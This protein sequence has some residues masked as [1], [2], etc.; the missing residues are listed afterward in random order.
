MPSTIY[1]IIT[2]WDLK[3]TVGYIGAIKCYWHSEGQ[4]IPSLLRVVISPVKSVAYSD[5]ENESN[6]TNLGGSVRLMT[7]PATFPIRTLMPDSP[8]LL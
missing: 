8:D 5:F 1:D 4:I 2:R 7:M 3:V 6:K